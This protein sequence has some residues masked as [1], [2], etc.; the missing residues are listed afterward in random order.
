VRAN[1]D[2][3][4]EQLLQHFAERPE[5]Q[6]QL[7]RALLRRLVEPGAVGAV[8]RILFGRAV[9]WHDVDRRAA[10]L[11]DPAAKLALV[12][13]ALARAPGDPE[14]EARAL[15]LLLQLGRSRDAVARARRQR[16]QGLMTPMLARQLGE[17]LVA[18]GDEAAGQRAFSELV[19]FDPEDPS[20]RALLGD[21]FLS[22]GWF[23]AAYRQYEELCELASE[24]DGAKIRLA[25][26]A[27]GAGRS[28]E[29]L[30]ILRRLAGGEGRPGADDPRRWARA[31]AAALL[32]ELLERSAADAEP[33]A[34]ARELRRLQLFDA[35]V[36]WRILLWSD[37]EQ[38]LELGSGAEGA[39]WRADT[40]DAGDTGLWAAAL[41]DGTTP[42]VVVRHVGTVPGREV[43]FA[44]LTLTWDGTRFE[45]RRET[46]TLAAGVAAV[47][48]GAVAKP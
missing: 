22:H 37:L 12:E 7:A 38:R 24:D 1:S 34:V 4:V 8:H 39:S 15:A 13:Q 20:S 27:H 42:P 44:V 32:A 45:A 46:G 19:E 5:A 10:L 18:A 31:H 43:P 47:S 21:V 40:I 16:D 11:V 48:L 23:D 26:A 9:D 3:D 41:A 29:A 6:R 30:R 17:S 35:P 33:E 25:R 2:G 36:V 28:D 14:G